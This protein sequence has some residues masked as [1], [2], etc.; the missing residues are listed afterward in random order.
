MSKLQSEKQDVVVKEDF[1]QQHILY[2]IIDRVH[3]VQVN[4]QFVKENYM[5]YMILKMEIYLNISTMWLLLREIVV[6]VKALAPKI[7]GKCVVMLVHLHIK[8]SIILK[9]IIIQTVLNVQILGTITC[10]ECSRYRY[11]KSRKSL[12]RT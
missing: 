11:N 9:H 7:V 1:T 10:D 2:Q 6:Y 5:E 12:Q 8:V 4:V 3:Q